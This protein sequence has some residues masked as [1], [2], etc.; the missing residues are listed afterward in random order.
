METQVQQQTLLLLEQPNQSLEIIDEKQEP[1]P[2]QFYIISSSYLLYT[3]T[4]S[5]LRMIV[6]FELYKR[7]YNA[8]EIAIMF[9]FYELVGVG[10]NLFGGIVGT[11]HGLKF[12]L[13]LG[14]FCQLVG[15]SLLLVVLWTDSWSSIAVIV[16]VTLVQSFSGVAK[17]LVKLAGKSSTKLIKVLKGTHEDSLFK[18]VAWLT[19]AKNSVKGLGFFLGAALINYAGYWP[20]LL[21]LFIIILCTLP[22]GFY[23]DNGIGQSKASAPKSLKQIFTQDT[24][25]NLLSF[26]RML[27]F[28][29]RDV[30]F[31]IVL[32]IYLR[33]SY[34]WEYIFAGTVMAL[35]IIFYGAIQSSTP[36]LILSRLGQFPLKHGKQLVPWTIILGVICLA[37]SLFLSFYTVKDTV[38]LTVFL[39]GIYVF[40][41]VFAVNSSIHSYL[42]VAYSDKDKVSMTVGFYY[43]S[44]ALGRLL[45]TLAS[46]FLYYYFGLGACLW[47]SVVMLFLCTFATNRLKPVPE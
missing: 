29:S 15:I 17:D 37:L 20:S 31:E 25:V 21:V 18:V 41:F 5:A 19:G 33:N 16:Y 35:W 2:I 14:L 36:T 22:L 30:W 24:S 13:L 40:G 23:L 6:L 44:N 32:P 7:K 46:G 28:G 47:A 27:L 42:I 12:S 38:Q 10:T 26:A 11:T 39:V 8:I 3:I 34:S 43:M 4:D 45:G 9:S 1:K